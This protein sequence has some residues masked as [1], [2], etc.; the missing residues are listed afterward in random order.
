MSV[1]NRHTTTDT[2]IA[3]YTTRVTPLVRYLV[4]RAMVNGPYK[5]LDREWTGSQAWVAD[6]KERYRCKCEQCGGETEMRSTEEVL[7]RELLE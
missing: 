2:E 6:I 1:M 7:G 4:R 5:L 3:P